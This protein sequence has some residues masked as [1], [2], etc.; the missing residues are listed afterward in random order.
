MEK[1]ELRKVSIK[2]RVCCY[3]D[4]IIKFQDFDLDDILL[5]G[6]Q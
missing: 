6:K 3:F 1:N 5:D 4:D 2:Y